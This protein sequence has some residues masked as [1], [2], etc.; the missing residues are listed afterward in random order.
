[1]TDRWSAPPL[2]FL[3]YR[4]SSYTYKYIYIYICIF[5]YMP[6]YKNLSHLI[7][8]VP[9]PPLSVDPK[10]TRFWPWSRSLGLALLMP[11]WPWT[12]WSVWGRTQHYPS[13]SARNQPAVKEQGLSPQH[14]MGSWPPQILKDEGKH[15]PPHKSLGPESESDP[16]LQPLLDC[17]ITCAC[18]RWTSSQDSCCPHLNRWGAGPSPPLPA[19]ACWGLI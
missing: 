17:R 7:R 5:L 8:T 19:V 6:I 2:H 10:G 1:M 14:P 15:L 11:L 9:H 16:V 3:A 13:W 12:C 18:Q 4:E